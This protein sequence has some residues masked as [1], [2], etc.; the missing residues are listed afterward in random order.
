M[1]FGYL[2]I[3]CVAMSFVAADPLPD[4]DPQGPSSG[5]RSS[6]SSVRSPGTGVVLDGTPRDCVVNACGFQPSDDVGGRG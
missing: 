3:L 1:Q 5:I 6:V 2:L 4:P